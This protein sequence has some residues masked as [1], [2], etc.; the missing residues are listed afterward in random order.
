MFTIPLSILQEIVSYIVGP[1]YTLR[2]DIPEKL[3]D[4]TT[5]ATNSKAFHY[6]LHQHELH[7]TRFI[8]TD[9]IIPSY[10]IQWDLWCAT[11]NEE[12][13]EHLLYRPLRI[14]LY[15]FCTNPHPRA[16][17]TI[18]SYLQGKSTIFPS[19]SESWMYICMNPNDRIVTLLLEV[20]ETMVW[21]PTNPKWW[22]TWFRV[23]YNHNERIAQYFLT[24]PGRIGIFLNQLFT[25]PS[26][27][28]TAY[29][30]AHYS[31]SINWSIF[32]Q[33]KSDCAARYMLSHKEHVIWNYV[34]FNP[35]NLLLDYLLDHPDKINWYFLSQNS[36]PRA[37]EFM[38]KHHRDKIYWGQVS[39]SMTPALF[40][41]NEEKTKE[42]RQQWIIDYTQ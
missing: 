40:E 29:L 35:N 30:L 22:K 36:N 13:I 23:A 10:W 7:H 12:V 42:R 28:L 16:T 5:L 3:L 25:H 19:G 26:E 8:T 41:V 33:N 20:F 39:Q 18:I 11:P 31:E 32:C 14:H 2:N 38:L 1:Y 6:L 4:K 9:T 15:T 37:L 17:D 27:T 34:C 24:H 21:E